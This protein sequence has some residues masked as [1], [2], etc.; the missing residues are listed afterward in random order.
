MASSQKPYEM[1]SNT[2]ISTC[3]EEIGLGTLSNLPKVTQQPHH[4][5]PPPCDL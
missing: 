2:I 1:G 5:T 3:N 4:T